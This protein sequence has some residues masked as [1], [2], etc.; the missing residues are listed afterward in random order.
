MVDAIG[1][2]GASHAKSGSSYKAGS[3]TEPKR[4]LRAPLLLDV[5]VHTGAAREGG[6]PVCPVAG[7]PVTVLLATLVLALS[8]IWEL[9][10]QMLCVNVHVT[11][12]EYHMNC[13]Q[14]TKQPCC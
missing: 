5:V 12:E 2:H 3:H 6:S 8:E 10:Q 4:L 1:C 9:E 11:T 13:Y 14:T 7:C